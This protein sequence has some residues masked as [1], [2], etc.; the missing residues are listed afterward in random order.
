MGQ[1]RF[2][3]RTTA[4]VLT[5][6]LFEMM[7]HRSMAPV[8][9]GLWSPLYVGLML[10]QAGTI[11]ALVLLARY[12]LIA[13]DM[14]HFIRMPAARFWWGGALLVY[15]YLLSVYLR[16]GDT[17]F[18]NLAVLLLNF[19][20]LGGLCMVV[21]GERWHTLLKRLALSA[22]V[23]ILATVLIELGLMLAPGVGKYRADQMQFLEMQAANEQGNAAYQ[24]LQE[25]DPVLGFTM[26]PNAQAQVDYIVGRGG[27]PELTQLKTDAW[28][29]LNENFDPEAPCD[30]VTVGDSFVMGWWPA[31]MGRQTGLRVVNLGRARYCPP[32]YTEVVKRYALR[33]R[34]RL[35]VYCLY[36]NDAEEAEDYLDW[37][38]SGLDWFEHKGGFWFGPKEGRPGRALV[39][40]DLTRVSRIY[41]LIGLLAFQSRLRGQ[42]VQSAGPLEFK[43]GAI[44]LR[45]DPNS[46]ALLADVKREKVRRGLEEVRRDV[47]AARDTCAA[48]GVRMVV[49]LM[50]AKELVYD[51]ELAQVA[52]AGAPVGNVAALYAE[53]R[54]IAERAGVEVVDLQEIFRE[55]A[56]RREGQLYWADDIHWN[57]EG[58]AFMAKVGGDVLRGL[59]IVGVE[60]RE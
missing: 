26:R 9:F 18:K 28:G 40:R 43:R 4:V 20:I 60:D 8:V 31:E 51:R 59:G 15:V 57:P 56:G 49:F 23:L 13:W 35:I 17:D 39:R 33:L 6:L 12:N 53:F 38:A 24:T 58:T 48:A 14:A 41:N 36:L 32:Q 55:E 22:G 21:W 29:F 47:E 25:S 52:P 42:G 2:F 19:S 5:L 34:P 16:S 46:Y 54:G 11:A 7:G 3:M 37:Q 27:K 30:V 10:L 1:A 45:F 50:P 44:E